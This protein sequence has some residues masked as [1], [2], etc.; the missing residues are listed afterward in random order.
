MRQIS[1]TRIAD[2]NLDLSGQNWDCIISSNDVHTS[3]KNFV[4]ICT[5]LYDKHCP[6]KE[7][8]VCNNDLKPWFTKCLRNACKK[9]NRLYR[10]F[11][12]HRS[13]ENETRY[14]LYRNKLTFIFIAAEKKNYSKLLQKYKNDVKGTWKI[15]NNVIKKKKGTCTYFPE[16]VKVGLNGTTISDKNEIA[17]GFNNFFVNIGPNL[18]NNLVP[19]SGDESIFDYIKAPVTCFYLTQMNSRLLRFCES[20]NPKH[21]LDMIVLT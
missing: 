13:L 10:R 7:K 9:K 8:K 16:F 1:D 4:N 15:L 5:N 3:Y 19:P 20:V 17:D 6:F 2:L 18:A 12:S 11:L 14:K 21:L